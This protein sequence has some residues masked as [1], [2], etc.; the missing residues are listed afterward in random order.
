MDL[1]S[2]WIKCRSPKM[3]SALRP[4][5]GKRTYQGHLRF[6]R[7]ADT[8]EAAPG[9]AEAFTFEAAE[10]GNGGP[11]LKSVS[12]SRS[13]ASQVQIGAVKYKKVGG[14]CTKNAPI[15]LFFIFIDLTALTFEMQQTRRCTRGPPPDRTFCHFK[16]KFPMWIP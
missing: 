12:V 11:T 10:L 4:H 3:M 16:W 14:R 9:R 13:V 8:R 6:C 15:L 2:S 7:G 1:N 5:G